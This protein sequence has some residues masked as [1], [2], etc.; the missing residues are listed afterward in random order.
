MEWPQFLICVLEITLL[1]IQPNGNP[2][3][4]LFSQ[5]RL[6]SEQNIWIRNSDVRNMNDNVVLNAGAGAG[7]H[8]PG[9][10]VRAKLLQAHRHHHRGKWLIIPSFV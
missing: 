1:Q 7:D 2:G 6:G 3:T 8:V 4:E 9:P 5:T 10:A